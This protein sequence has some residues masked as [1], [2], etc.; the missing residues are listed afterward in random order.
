MDA[1]QQPATTAKVAS[2]W[3]WS[4]RQHHLSDDQT[5]ATVATNAAL[6]W[7]DW[8]TNFP[9]P[10]PLSYSDLRAYRRLVDAAAEVP[11]PPVSGLTTAERVALRRFLDD[12]AGRLAQPVEIR[13]AALK[14]AGAALSLWGVAAY[15]WPVLTPLVAVLVAAIALIDFGRTGF[16]EASSTG[17]EGVI[18]KLVEIGKKLE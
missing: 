11:H 10:F 9:E 5:I 7:Q 18:M 16:S 15:V 17:A 4:E 12:H 14:A 13:T 6:E 3:P 1:R 2:G 8:Q